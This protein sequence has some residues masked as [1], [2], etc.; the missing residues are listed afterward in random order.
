[1]T[2]KSRGRPIYVS[3]VSR[4]T[5]CNNLLTL[6]KHLSPSNPRFALSIPSHQPSCNLCL[7]SFPNTFSN[8][9]LIPFIPH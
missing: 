7:Q 3:N 5:I 8:S 2:C 1:M 4:I 6:N 9:L